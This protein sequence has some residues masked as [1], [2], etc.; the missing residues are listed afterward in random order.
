MDLHTERVIRRS[1]L[2]AVAKLQIFLDTDSRAIGPFVG[3]GSKTDF[4]NA[5]ILLPV[6]VQF[7]MED[8]KL[9]IRGQLKSVLNLIEGTAPVAAKAGSAEQVGT[10]AGS[11]A[12]PGGQ[13]NIAVADFQADGVSGTDAAVIANLLRGELVKT[14]A[15]NV[16]EKR[17]MDKILAEQ[18]FQQTG[19]TTQECAVKVGKLLNVQRMI[20]GNCGFLLGKYFV[21]IR[22]VNVETGKA[23]YADEAKGRA[24]EDIELGIKAIAGRMSA[25]QL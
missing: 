2:M 15:F 1:K 21:N 17:N 4:G 13:L 23:T 9:K 12:A 6:A 25:R 16:I 14:R 24:V 18:A 8:A 3:Y 10:T 22:V 19:C 11:I 20:V 5:S 7:A